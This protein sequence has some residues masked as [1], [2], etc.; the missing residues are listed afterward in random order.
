M[1]QSQLARWA[2]WIQWLAFEVFD[3][4]DIR[5]RGLQ[6][7]IERSVFLLNACGF[8]GA[9]LL[10]RW[11]H[12]G[13]FLFVSAAVY[14]ISTLIR[15]RFHADGAGASTRVL[16]GGYEGALT[17]T[18]TLAAAALIERFNGTNIT[19]ALLLEGEMIVL[20]G[21]A[22][23]NRFVRGLGGAV[24]SL[25][26]L[27]MTC[28]DAMAS[29][30]VRRWTPIALLMAAVFVA[31]R[32]KGGWA[33]TTGAGILLAM[34][35]GAEIRREWLCFAWAVI[36]LVALLIASPRKWID[37][38]IQHPAWMSMTFVAGAIATTYGS[39][40]VLPVTLTVLLFYVCELLFK[41][42]TAPDR[43]ARI[44]VLLNSVLG[45]S[46][47]TILLF[48]EVQ[49]RLLTVALGIEGA[50]LL[51]AGIALSER[52]MRLSGLVLFL[53]CI[54]KAFL[55]DLRQ[56][57]TFS[58]IVSFIVLGLLLLGA[59]WVYTRFRERIRRLL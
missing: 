36:G 20:A 37:V 39:R 7:G 6:R 22:L 8:I 23:G 35:A 59:S 29:G 3:L 11:D 19:L 44:A 1:L 14:L 31:N 27:H 30:P 50:G 34:G 33:Y 16:G 54:G 5:R 51:V 2:L 25:A 57:D 48:H 28:V 46:L 53:L 52:I 49:G 4:L 42:Y 17:A 9:S 10:Y 40:A 12:V 58:R 43:L 55:Y 18:A 15:A 21:H 13:P 41:N 56:L 38:L 45:T 32:L 47:L 24:L 26:F